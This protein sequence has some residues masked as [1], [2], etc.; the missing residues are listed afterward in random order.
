MN[1]DTSNLLNFDAPF[2]LLHF[3]AML[4][5]TINIIGIPVM[6]KIIVVGPLV[7]PGGL[8]ILPFIF[9][10]EDIIVELYGFKVSRFLLWLVLASTIIFSLLTVWIVHLPS[11]TYWH[12]Q[13]IYNIVFDPILKVGFSSVL[14]VFVG[15]FTNII[16]MTKWKIMMKG[17][18]F[19][20]R[21]IFST[22]IGSALALAVF[23]GLSF[24]G[25]V[26]LKAIETLFLSDIAV[27]VGYTVIGGLPVAFL[28]AYLKNKIGLDTF[29]KGLDFNPF[30][31]N[32]KNITEEEI[33]L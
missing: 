6:Y 11:P 30:S 21:S 31:L 16:L 17:R 2:K 19:W 26:S 8:V 23:F 7:G 4:Y 1:N 29:E 25:T 5:Y 13:E 15:R 14:A 32:T 10:L 33:K 22:F 9:L 28:V 20:I 24:T 18:F 27:R 12:K 3:L